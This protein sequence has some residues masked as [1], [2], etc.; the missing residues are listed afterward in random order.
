MTDPSA[1]RGDGAYMLGSMTQQAKATPYKI[2]VHIH[3]ARGLISKSA[4]EH[5]QQTESDACMRVAKSA[6]HA[7]HVRCSACLPLLVVL[8]SDPNHLS[9]ALCIVEL[10]PLTRDRRSTSL[11]EATMNAM[12]NETFEWRDIK[13]TKEEFAT[14]KIAFSVYHKNDF[15]RNSL[16][17]QQHSNDT[18]NRVQ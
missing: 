16:I 11:Q 15:K 12:W 2:F 4:A 6:H 14:E 5:T 17:G 9:D 18:A 10:G 13:L 7:P 3:E 1:F 8:P